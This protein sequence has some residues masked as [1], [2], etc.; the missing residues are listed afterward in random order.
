MKD[1]DLFLLFKGLSQSLSDI[2]Q[3]MQCSTVALSEVSRF[4]EDGLHQVRRTRRTQ[5]PLRFLFRTVQCTVVTV[6]TA[7]ADFG[8]IP[9]R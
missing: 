6:D 8:E 3:M 4:F 5:E 9:A 7:C 2:S 1:S